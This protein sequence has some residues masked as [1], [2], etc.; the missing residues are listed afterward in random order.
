MSKNRQMNIKNISK[1][2][3]ALSN[4]LYKNIKIDYV[5]VV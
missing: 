4:G 2:E 1:K 3:V 5:V